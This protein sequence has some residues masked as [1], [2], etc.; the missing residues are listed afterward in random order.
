MPNWTY[1]RVHGSNKIV[2]ELLDVEGKPTFKNIVP[3]P[4]ELQLLEKAPFSPNKE[5]CE[6]IYAY[7]VNHDE[8]PLR[9]LYKTGS[10]LASSYTSEDAYVQAISEMSE[11][12]IS[13]I[14]TLHD[15]YDGCYGWYDWDIH[16]W[17]CKWDAT[18]DFGPYNGTED[19]IEFETPWCPPEGVI[20]EL[21]NRFPYTKF[22]WHADEESCLFSV[23]Y[24]AHGDGSFSEHDVPPEYYLPCII[25]ED[26]LLTE[27][28]GLTIV[29]D[30]LD[31]IA[32]QLGEA[33]HDINKV[34]EPD[35]TI[36][37]ELTVYDWDRYGGGE[38]Y[39]TKIGGL[40]NE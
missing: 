9:D 12:Y 39:S 36:S 33:E 34:E 20:S 6:A 14:R 1:N 29:K 24:V 13:V 2:R 40:K 38:L 5:L 4:V 11:D 27:L 30:V 26:D 8:E 7:F 10:Y 28:Q 15:R 16:F 31:T 32:T 25:E 17:G 19:E 18:D 22:V 21:I 3:P 35:G 23:D 37:L